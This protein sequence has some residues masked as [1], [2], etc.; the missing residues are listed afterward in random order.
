[1]I[2]LGSGLK[3]IVSDYCVINK[4]TRCPHCEK[5]VKLSIPDKEWHC[6]T[7]KLARH[8]DKIIK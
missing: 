5:K 2:C 6:N 3:I 1:M 7:A 4:E 8:S